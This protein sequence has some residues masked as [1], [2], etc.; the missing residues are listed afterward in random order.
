MKNNF[1]YM[2]LTLVAVFGLSLVSCNDD[3]TN[4]SRKVLASVDVLV[5]DAQPT[6]PQ[7]ITVTS[8]A[9]WVAEASEWISVSPASGSAG[10]TEVEITVNDNKRGGEIDNPRSGTVKFIGRSLESI[11]SVLIRQNGDKFRDPVDYTIESLNSTAD[12]TIVRL[13]SLTVLAITGN[14]YIATDGT[15]NVYITKASDA[16][17]ID[18]VAV[19]DKMDV[20][21]EKLTDDMKFPYVA[22]GKITN[23]GTGN[24]PAVS[25]E[26]I[27]GNLDN[28]S[29]APYSYI[30]VT[31]NFD[32]IQNAIV[33]KGFANQAFVADVPANIN[34]D[35]LGGHKVTLNGYYAGTAT[36]VVRFIPVE[37]I[38]HGLNETVYFFDDFEWLD[39]WCSLNNIHDYVAESETLKAESKNLE[40]VN[41][42]GKTVMAE[43]TERGYDFVKVNA[44]DK[45]DDRPFETRIYI[46]RNYLKFS[47]TGIEAGVVLPIIKGIPEG[48]DCELC[49]SWSPM[50]QGDPGKKNRA[51]DNI[52][53]IVII[54]NAGS[55]VKIPVPPHTLKNGDAH[56][57]M[58]AVIDLSGNKIDENTKITIRSSDDRWPAW[59]AEAGKSVV[60]RWFFDNVKVRAAQ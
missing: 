10:Q 48:Q 17:K 43:L 11:A 54:E 2:L 6:G 30:T 44:A 7:I 34:L 1:K 14:G 13:P 21:G 41:A 50:R 28:I 52:S 26:D 12:E 40:N 18:N 19:G 51:Y 5:Y 37:M 56:E 24:L 58:N 53:L 20:V 8:D 31:G 23:V 22:G 42:D 3:E 57:W 25:P 39:P 36:P 55:M 27:S 47:L 32:D 16:I 29:L 59:D 35:N 49:F 15:D 45:T 60:N 4:M 38:D 33:I 9:D 46:Q